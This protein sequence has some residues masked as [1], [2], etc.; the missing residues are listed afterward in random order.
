MNTGTTA[1][2]VR[3]WC[4]I[5][6]TDHAKKNRLNKLPRFWREY[7]ISV[8]NYLTKIKRAYDFSWLEGLPYSSAKLSW[9]LQPPAAFEP[10]LTLS[11]KYC[12]TIKYDILTYTG[13]TGHMLSRKLLLT[14]SSRLVRPYEHLKNDCWGLRSSPK[15]FI[16]VYSTELYKRLETTRLFVEGIVFSIRSPLYWWWADSHEVTL[17]DLIH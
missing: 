2:T 7:S 9:K 10:R 13:V 11:F 8:P 3:R 16:R 15:P 14:W 17:E 1:S 5:K 4:L 12:N 6:N